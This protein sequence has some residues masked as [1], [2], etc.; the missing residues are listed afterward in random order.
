MRGIG[1]GGA[2]GSAGQRIAQL[3]KCRL[4]FGCITGLRALL[5]GCIDAGCE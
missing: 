3:I 4:A 1:L 5:K 2:N